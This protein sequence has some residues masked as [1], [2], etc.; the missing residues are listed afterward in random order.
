MSAPVFVVP[1][2]ALATVSAGSV[3]RL[4][5]GEGRHAVTVRRLSVAEPI[6]LV[7]GH[8]RSALGRVVEI[9]GKDALTVDVESVTDEAEGQPR[10][11]VAQALAKGDRGELAV[12]LLTEVG[13]DEIIPWAA[14]N[15]VVRWREDRADKARQRWADA[16]VAAAKQARRSRFPE[17]AAV[18]S[19]SGL[20]DRV[21]GAALALVLHEEASMPLSGVTVPKDGEILLVVG[22]EGGISAA[23]IDAL[24]GVGAVAVRLGPT[25]MRTSSAGMAAAAALLA[26][27]ER[28]SGM[29]RRAG[30][31]RS[32]ETGPATAWKDD[33]HE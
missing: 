26:R 8:G 28:W 16:C 31:G 27:T 7:D 19:T 1:R 22:P 25:V 17:L 24:T 4:D 23:E 12:E 14:A 5:G 2:E 3:V 11:V 20:A 9:L 29:E 30:P 33:H 10:F 13:V 15:C 6:R 21:A 18:V 32:S